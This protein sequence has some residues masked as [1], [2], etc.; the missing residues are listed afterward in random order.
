VQAG[1]ALEALIRENQHFALLCD[2]EKADKR[3]LPA[4]LRVWWRKAHPETEYSAEDPTGGYLLVLKEILEWMITH[5]DP[6]VADGM[7]IAPAALKSGTAD[8]EV[9][10]S[11]GPHF[12]ISG[13]AANPRSES[14]IRVNY[15]DAT[16]ITSGSSN[17]GGNGR[18]AMYFSTD[19]GANWGQTF[20]PFTGS[21]TFHSD[22][23][24]DWTSDGRAWS[25]TLGIQSSG[26]GIISAQT[27]ARRGPSRRHLPVHR[28]ASTSRWSGWTRAR[29]RRFRT[30]C[31]RVWH[32]GLPAF[33]NRRTAGAGGAWLAAPV[34]VSGSESTG[35]AIGS[36][37]KT[38]S[39]GHVFAAWPTTGNRRILLIKSTDGG[40]TY[41][42]SS[43]RDHV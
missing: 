43:D 30:G 19:G 8:A 14:D 24:V 25:S 18:Q 27:T 29:A 36:D 22:P 20:L 6:K 10:A 13:P 39:A 17:I 26:C 31:M 34:Q 28:P 42:A 4:W 16:K 9:D 3:N 33:M 41:R 15:F 2:D 11:T 23:T 1:S 5:Q 32:N 37:V 12:R 35:T 40:S 38:N 7:N 21:D